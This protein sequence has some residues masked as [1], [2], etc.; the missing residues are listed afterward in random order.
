[1]SFRVSKGIVDEDDTTDGDDTCYGGE[2]ESTEDAEP[3]ETRREGRDVKGAGLG[4]R[5]VGVEGV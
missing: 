3:F 5:K 4:L 1:M 2:G